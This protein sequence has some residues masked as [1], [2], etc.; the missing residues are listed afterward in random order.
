MSGFSGASGVPKKYVDDLVAQ[1][2]ANLTGCVCKPVQ[3]A[4]YETTMTKRE[5][6]VTLPQG[7]T[8]IGTCGNIRE[9]NVSNLN[10]Y[11]PVLHSTYYNSST[12][13]IEYVTSAAVN[14]PFFTELFVF[15]KF[16]GA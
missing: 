12:G 10:Y 5:A 11:K 6:D 15:Y 13:K 7:A 8:A 4:A 2:T 3:Y 1:S 9:T 16:G 14:G